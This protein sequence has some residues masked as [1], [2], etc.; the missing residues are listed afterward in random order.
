MLVKLNCSPWQTKLVGASVASV[1][2]VPGVKV[3]GAGSDVTGTRGQA[4]TETT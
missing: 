1:E 2:P 4:E 3:T